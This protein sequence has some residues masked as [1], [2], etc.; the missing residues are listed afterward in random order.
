MALAG[1]RP[2]SA[3]VLGTVNLAAPEQIANLVHRTPGA[4]RRLVYR[5]ELTRGQ[6]FLSARTRRAMY[7]A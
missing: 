2:R 5:Q 6:P 3:E 7:Y 1:T 4:V